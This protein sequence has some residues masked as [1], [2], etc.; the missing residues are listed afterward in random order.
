MKANDYFNYIDLYKLEDEIEKYI[1]SEDDLEI[2]EWRTKSYTVILVKHKYKDFS[3][4]GEKNFVDS[5][6]ISQ[7]GIHEYDV[8]SLL[9]YLKAIKSG[10]NYKFDEASTQWINYIRKQLSAYPELASDYEK[11]LAYYLQSIQ[12]LRVK[13]A[14]KIIKKD[15]D[16]FTK[17]LNINMNNNI[18]L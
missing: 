12:D 5:Y 13:E 7:F 4:D 11:D 14:E 2:E 10:Y 3:V 6:L 16:K 1:D 17:K 9:S 18:N 8:N 15:F